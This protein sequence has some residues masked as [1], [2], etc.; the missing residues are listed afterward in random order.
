[1]V[2]DTEKATTIKFPG[3]WLTLI[4]EGD[5]YNSPNGVQTYDYSGVKMMFQGLKYPTLIPIEAMDAFLGGLRDNA[6]FKEIYQIL[7][8][9]SDQ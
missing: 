1:M 7:Q 2:N 8:A 5:K 4:K 9:A 3:G 6:K